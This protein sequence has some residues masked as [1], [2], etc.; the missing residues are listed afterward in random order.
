MIINGRSISPGKAKGVAIVYPEPFSFL[1]GV[2]GS[3]GRFNV[4]D[5]DITDKVFVFPNG[6]GSTV[7]SYVVYD[8]KVHG[9]APLALV[10]RSAETIVTTGSVI[11]DVP[12]VDGVDISLIRDGDTLEV[13]G[14]TGAL[15]IVGIKDT[16]V[17]MSFIVRDGKFLMVHREPHSHAYP[18]KWTL[19]TSYVAKGVDLDSAV[20]DSVKEKTG[21]AVDAPAG[22]MDAIQFRGKH[23]IYTVH[24]Y[25]FKVSSDEVTLDADNTEYKWVSPEEFDSEETID[26]VAKVVS[27]FTKLI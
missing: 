22:T 11:S 24:A 12:M 13:D 23:T 3:T 25:M 27:N 8:L 10:N 5:G 17:I 21:I 26:A 4:M 20:I 9:H 14:D 1:G 2:D 7:G 19:V 6:K 18:S 15:E 16:D